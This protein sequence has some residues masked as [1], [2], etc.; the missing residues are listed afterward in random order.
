MSAQWKRQGL[1]TAS[2][3]WQ[4]A[5][6]AA[7]A[8]SVDIG[9]WVMPNTTRRRGNGLAGVAPPSSAATKRRCNWGRVVA[10]SDSLSGASSSRHS[11]ACQR[12]SAGSGGLAAGGSASVRGSVSWPSAQ[13]A[14]QSLR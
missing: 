7:S 5:D 1:G 13:A 2:T 3:T 12:W 8:T 14:S 6:S 4:C 11:A 10:R 9:R